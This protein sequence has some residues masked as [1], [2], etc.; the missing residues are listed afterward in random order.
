MVFQLKSLL[1]KNVTAPTRA[2]VPHVTAVQYRAAR[3][4]AFETWA[5]VSGIAALAA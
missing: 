5:E 1:V 3:T 2:T 4:R